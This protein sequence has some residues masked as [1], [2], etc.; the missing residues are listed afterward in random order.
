MASDGG[1]IG[2][3]GGGG[4]EEGGKRERDGAYNRL[5]VRRAFRAR[6]IGH[7]PFVSERNDDS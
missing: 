1:E 6:L 3:G 4:V 5:P 7:G 2:V